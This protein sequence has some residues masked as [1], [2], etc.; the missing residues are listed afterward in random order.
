MNKPVRAVRRFLRRKGKGKGKGSTGGNPGGMGKGKG[1]VFLAEMS[2]AEVEQVFKGKGKG[3]QKQQDA[4]E[5]GK[6]APAVDAGG[7]KKRKGSPA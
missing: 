7:K 2:D 1:K 4:I 5:S 6:T 3:A